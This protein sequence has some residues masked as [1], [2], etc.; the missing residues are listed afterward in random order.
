MGENQQSLDDLIEFDTV[1]SK[2]SKLPVTN[3]FAIHS[4]VIVFDKETNQLIS[5]GGTDS[6]SKLES[7][8]C[9]LDLTNQQ[10]LEWKKTRVECKEHQGL[11]WQHSGH[12]ISK[13]IL[14]PN[15][16]GKFL[17]IAGGCVQPFMP[18]KKIVEIDIQS[19][20][21][22]GVAEL[23]DGIVSHDSFIVRDALYLFGGSNGT[24]FNDKVYKIS[25]GKIEIVGSYTGLGCACLPLEEVTLIYGGAKDG[26]SFNSAFLY[27]M[28]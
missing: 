3:S 20:K 15:S 28:L 11:I 13:S 25:N 9:I 16:E 14:N 17:L 18:Y 7:L 6:E 8:L 24:G 5:Y 1:T 10:N 27:T 23:D 21:V 19:K 26:E 22:S 4:A 2:L 12:L